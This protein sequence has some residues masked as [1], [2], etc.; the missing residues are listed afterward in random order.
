MLP[1]APEKRKHRGLGHDNDRIGNMFRDPNQGNLLLRFANNFVAF[2]HSW[3]F[4]KFRMNGSANGVSEGVRWRS[5]SALCCSLASFLLLFKLCF[6]STSSAFKLLLLLSE[7][8]FRCSRWL[9][10]MIVFEQNVRILLLLLAELVT[11]LKKGGGGGRR[12]RSYREESY[13]PTIAALTS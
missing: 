7:F 12:L 3:A 10:Q 4:L 13:S 2:S 8:L 6:Q 1:R 11:R 9:G 5:T